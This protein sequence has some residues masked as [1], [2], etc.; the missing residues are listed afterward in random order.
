MLH[1]CVAHVYS[2]CCTCVFMCVLGRDVL[3]MGIVCAA[4]VC[5]V[6]HMCIVCV[7]QGCSV[8]YVC[9]EWGC[10]AHVCSVACVCAAHVCSV[11][12]TCVVLHV[13]QMCVVLHCV[14][15]MCNVARVKCCMC[16]AHVCLGC[17]GEF[18]FPAS[19]TKVNWWAPRN[20]QY[21]SVRRGTSVRRM[22]LLHTGTEVVCFSLF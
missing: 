2:M 19:T 22:R 9:L 10:V 5:G 20:H 12:H 18:H 13:L 17:V 4:H 1:M 8:A 3:D 6:S 7:A 14:A 11:L 21:Q 15:H 16:V